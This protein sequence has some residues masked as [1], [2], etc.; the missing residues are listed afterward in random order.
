MV[1]RH[2]KEH[3]MFKRLK[4]TTGAVGALAALGLGGA[5]IAG[6]TGTSPTK[7]PATVNAPEL[8][9]QPDKDNI[10]SGDQT[11]PDTGSATKAEV[12]TAGD[13]RDTAA[14]SGKAAGATAGDTTDTTSEAATSESSTSETPSASD[15][16][17]GHADEPGNPNANT[18][19]QGQN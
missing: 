12:A 6:A 8:T 4:I 17:G 13:A 3:H 11:T 7:V 16:P 15:G 18:D 10:Q 1:N 9:S 2:P 14:T 19:Q 5:A